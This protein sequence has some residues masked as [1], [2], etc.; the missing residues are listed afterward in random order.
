[1]VK[2]FRNASRKFYKNCFYYDLFHGAKAWGC[3]TYLSLLRKFLHFRKNKIR[4]IFKIE[5]AKPGLFLARSK[6]LG[7]SLQCCPLPTYLGGKLSSGTEQPVG[8]KCSN[9]RF[10][11][12]C[13]N[14]VCCRGYIKMTKALRKA[15]IPG[16]AYCYYESIVDLPFETPD[17]CVLKACT[18]L[19]AKRNLYR[20]SKLKAYAVHG[21]AESLSVFRTVGADKKRVYRIIF[22]RIA[23]CH[24]GSDFAKTSLV[25]SSSRY[26]KAAIMF[27]K[28]PIELIFEKPSNSLKLNAL[29]KGHRLVRRFGGFYNTSGDVPTK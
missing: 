18:A 4:C 26:G 11:A 17:S 23:Y 24:S 22:K 7:I 29:L 19:C 25:T 2:S 13:W 14:R 20:A 5:R 27:C 8:F 1:M 3:K 12:Y 16:Y 28:V 9:A 21:I 15:P 10:C 6:G